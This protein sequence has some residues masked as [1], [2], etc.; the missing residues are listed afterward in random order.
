LDPN[1]WI[2]NESNLIYTYPRCDPIFFLHDPI[3][4][5]RSFFFIQ[6]FHSDGKPCTFT[7]T[8]LGTSP[9]GVDLSLDDYPGEFIFGVKFRKSSQKNKQWE[10]SS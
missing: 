1:S 9:T 4:F 6:S 3:F 2:I 7:F 5:I 8:T 10:Y